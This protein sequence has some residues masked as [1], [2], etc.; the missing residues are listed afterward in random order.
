MP[1][2]IVAPTVVNLQPLDTHGG[3]VEQ[4]NHICGIPVQAA[5]GN[6]KMSIQLQLRAGYL[7]AIGQS[8]SGTAP[9][10]NHQICR[11][12]IPL[13]QDVREQSGRT[14]GTSAGHTI[15]RQFKI[16]RPQEVVE[17]GRVAIVG[18]TQVHHQITAIELLAKRAG[19]RILRQGIGHIRIAWGQQPGIGATGNLRKPVLQHLPIA[20]NI[21]S[22]LHV[23]Q[24]CIVLP[25]QPQ[26]VHIQRTLISPAEPIN[27][28]LGF[29][30]NRHSRL[31]GHTRQ[32]TIVQRPELR[33][34]RQRKRQGEYPERESGRRGSSTTG[35]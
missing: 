15:R 24:H 28:Q 2:R 12:N 1:Q 7:I 8:A 31:P 20:G 18:R 21:D 33:Q 23:V 16:D 4:Q 22:Q 17:T 3:K 10:T 9:V 35:K 6:L 26:P 13:Q 29:Q 11:P 27:A 19:D 25:G 30:L 5:V 14:P 32:C 34:R